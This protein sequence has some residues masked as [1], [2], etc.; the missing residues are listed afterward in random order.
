MKGFPR[1]KASTKKNMRHFVIIQPQVTS[2]FD[3]ETG[4][5]NVFSYKWGFYS[6][7]TKE[8]ALGEFVQVMKEKHP[9]PPDI[10]RFDVEIGE[11][12]PKESK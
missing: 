9:L 2:T 7:E 5:T 4:W 10:K 3:K 11:V 12:Y 1:C 8:Q 6:R